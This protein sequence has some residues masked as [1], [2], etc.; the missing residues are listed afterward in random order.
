MWYTYLG[1][2][3]SKEKTVMKDTFV[4]NSIDD[5]V[6]H[7]VNFIDDVT[8]IKV[9]KSLY[10]LYAYYG[11]TFGSIDYDNTESEFNILKTKYP[12]KL[13]EAKFEAWK[14]GPVINEVYA[15]QKQH[16]YDN[17]AET[18]PTISNWNE[19][20]LFID[21]LLEQLSVVNDFGLVTRSHQDNAW[22]NAYKPGLAHCDMD[23]EEII[24][25]YIG[26]VNAQSEI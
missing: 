2:F 6:A 1:G 13:F 14:Y 23:N 22:I 11:A 17:I 19:I 3:W 25:E 7:I 20:R 16:E 5:L 21:D 12:T 24:N 9:Q 15:K 8:P 10:F 26:Y 18:I 4:Y